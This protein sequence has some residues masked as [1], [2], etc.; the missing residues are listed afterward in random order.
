MSRRRPSIASAAAIASEPSP[1]TGGL[2]PDESRRPPVEGHRDR[3]DVLGQQPAQPAAGLGGVA[4]VRQR[5]VERPEQAAR[6]VCGVALVVH[7]EVHEARRPSVGGAQAHRHALAVARRPQDLRDRAGARLGPRGDVAHPGGTPLRS[8]PRSR[9]SATSARRSSARG[10]LG[11]GVVAE[12]LVAALDRIPG[13]E[14]S[15]DV[16]DA[17]CSAASTVRAALRARPRSTPPRRPGRHRHVHGGPRRHPAPIIDPPLS[18][19]NAQ[20]PRSVM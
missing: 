14:L 10:L 16:R 9:I 19:V 3:G 6:A 20:P 2:P 7:R 12:R 1:S 8:M 11:I 18:G 15:G 5:L 4:D 13:G 17:S